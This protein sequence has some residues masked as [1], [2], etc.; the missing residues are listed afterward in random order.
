MWLYKVS[1]PCKCSN[2]FVNIQTLQLRHQRPVFIK[3]PFAELSSCRHTINCFLIY[4]VGFESV[5]SLFTLLSSASFV[6]WH[7]NKLS[8]V[9]VQSLFPL[10]AEQQFLI[11]RLPSLRWTILRCTFLGH[12]FFL[13]SVSAPHHTSLSFC[14]FFKVSFKKT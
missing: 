3:L 13:L 2:I 8:V 1:Y 7:L 11:R 5:L 10:H 4:F 9:S 6:T 14:L 12:N